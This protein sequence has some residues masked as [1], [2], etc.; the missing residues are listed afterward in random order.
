MERDTQTV[1]FEQVVERGCGIDVHKSLLVATVR[2][3]GIDEETRE[4]GAFTEDI[5]SL[6]DWIKAKG[7]THIAMERS[8]VC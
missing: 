3:K 4:F 2:G 7:V 1:E 5:E 8:A 6:R